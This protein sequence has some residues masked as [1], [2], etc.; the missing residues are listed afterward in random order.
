MGKR[1][2]DS[3]PH[4]LGKKLKKLQKELERYKIRN[5]R[6]KSRSKQDSS[7]SDWSGDRRSSTP[8][9]YSSSSPEPET[10]TLLNGT[11]VAGNYIHIT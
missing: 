9:E 3:S 4:K 10:P 1:R 5:K 8:S 6:E 2:R 11:T 7:S